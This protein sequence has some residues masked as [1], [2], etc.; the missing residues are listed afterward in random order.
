VLPWLL[1]VGGEVVAHD[2]SPSLSTNDAQLEIEAVLAGHVIGMLS[3][4]SA[5][6]LIRAG[7]LVPLLSDHATDHLGVHVY[8]GSRTALPSRVRAFVDLAVER[9]AGST[10]Y[11]L[12]VRELAAA[13]ARGRRKRRRA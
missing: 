13:E 9:L 4:L 3:G 6:P 11:V 12:D 2:V 7:R 1:K 10:D 5:A 8:Y